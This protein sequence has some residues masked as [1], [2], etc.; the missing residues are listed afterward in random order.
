MNSQN[1][2]DTL[3]NIDS[4]TLVQLFG[5]SN[6][7]F[8]TCFCIILIFSL[9]TGSIGSYILHKQTKNTFIKN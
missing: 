8:N 2:D 4:N 3:T 1:T 7:Q 6:I 5:L 9:I